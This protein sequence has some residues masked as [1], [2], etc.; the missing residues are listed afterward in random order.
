MDLDTQGADHLHFPR[1]HVTRQAVGG[2]ADGE[3]AGR[4]GLRLENHRLETEQRQVVRRRQARR[5]RADDGHRPAVAEDQTSLQSGTEERRHLIGTR[6][7]QCAESLDFLQYRL[8]IPG[9]RTVH[10]AYEP[11][12]RP[13]GNRPV[14]AH[15]ESVPVRQRY[16][17][18]SAGRFAGRTAYAAADRGERVRA[19]RYQI[20]FTKAPL[21]DRAHIAARVRMHRTSDLT[22]NQVAMMMLSRQ[23]HAQRRH[24][25]ETPLARPLRPAAP[26]CM[27]NNLPSAIRHGMPPPAHPEA[28]GFSSS[29]ATVQRPRTRHTAS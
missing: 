27:R 25:P 1:D 7:K 18:A 22:G 4:N 9:F 14:H 17:A 10:L 21:G 13:D 28:C 16:L 15:E 19:A 29:R 2:D 8:R 3:H 24:D 20:S 12:E 26:A 5:P 6:R 11:L 23:I